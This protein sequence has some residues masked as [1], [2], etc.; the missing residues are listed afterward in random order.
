MVQYP[1]LRVLY[2]IPLY[3]NHFPSLFDFVTH[4]LIPLNFKGLLVRLFLPCCTFPTILYLLHTF[5]S[6]L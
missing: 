2:I 4:P 5:G 6:I 1:Q 3:Q